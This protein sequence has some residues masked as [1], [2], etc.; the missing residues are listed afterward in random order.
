LPVAALFYAAATLHSA[1]KYWS[2][3]G[4]KWKGRVQDRAGL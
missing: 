3:E 4:G 2:G 1:L